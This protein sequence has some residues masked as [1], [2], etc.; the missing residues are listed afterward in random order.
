MAT[1]EFSPDGQ[2]L[3]V[4]CKWPDVLVVFDMTVD[5]SSARVHLQPDVGV[6][7]R[8]MV[9]KDCSF[10]MNIAPTWSR[11][12]KFIVYRWKKECRVLRT[13][14]WS[15]EQPLKCGSD[16]LSP[17]FS[18]DGVHLAM[19]SGRSEVYI[20]NFQTRQLVK[21]VKGCCYSGDGNCTPEL[22]WTAD[23]THFA[24]RWK[25][26]AYV[27]DTSGNHVSIFDSKSDVYAL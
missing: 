10:L 3:L 14:N 21:K 4:G 1:V 25:T 22:Q 19:G 6:C 24:V 27:Y 26:G 11:D 5:S 7:D 15:L 16:V 18:P 20:W 9:S 2:K 12:G 8:M 13:D 23:G 17:K